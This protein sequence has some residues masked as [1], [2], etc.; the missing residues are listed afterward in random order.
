MIKQLTI[1]SYNISGGS[2]VG[3]T[4]DKTSTLLSRY[5]ID[6]YTK[7]STCLENIKK[8]INL[9][10]SYSFVGLQSIAEIENII[11]HT[12]IRNMS[13]TDDGYLEGGIITFYDPKRFKLINSILDTLTPL[14][15]DTEIVRECNILF[16]KEKTHSDNLYIVVNLHAGYFNEG[17]YDNDSLELLLSNII[18]KSSIRFENSNTKQNSK[19]DNT[20]IL[21]DL[22]NIYLI[23]MGTWNDSINTNYWKGISPFKY[24]GISKLKNLTAKLHNQPPFT[25]CVGRDSIRSPRN[26]NKDNISSDYIIYSNNLITSKNNNGISIENYIPQQKSD[27]TLN[28]SSNHLPIMAKLLHKHLLFPIKTQPLYEILDSIPPT[29]P[30][31]PGLTPPP[32]N[33]FS[34]DLQHFN[35]NNKLTSHYTRKKSIKRNT[36]KKLYFKRISTKNSRKKSIKRISTKNSKKKS[37]RLNTRKKS[38]NRLYYKR[39]KNSRKKSIKCKNLQSSK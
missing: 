33:S 16:L 5:C 1:L 32:E 37:I 26:K 39:S 28:P 23:M 2:L 17:F 30:T 35:F 19:K 36:R 27:S 29:P 18:T 14:K 8:Y 12:S 3:N 10:N 4:Q 24:T 21:P 20:I 11:K 25:C 9:K 7:Q 31:P 6:P 13:T 34:L 38:P 15:E 22:N